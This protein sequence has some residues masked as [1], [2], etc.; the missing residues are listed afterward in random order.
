MS[1][2][3][4]RRK[5][6]TGETAIRVLCFLLGVLLTIS[7]VLIK[8]R[9]LPGI[10][11]KD[12]EKVIESE[13]AEDT[14][15]PE[16]TAASEEVESEEVEVDLHE[17]AAETMYEEFV[18]ATQVSVTESVEPDDNGVYIID[19]KESKLNWNTEYPAL[20]EEMTLEEHAARETSYDT[21]LTA[22]A[23]DK[24]V[25]ESST[26]DFS[27]VKISIMGDSITAAT[28]LSDEEQAQYS[29]PKLLSYILG[30]E[31]VNLGIGGSVVS[32]NA[33][34][35]P[36]VERWSDIPEDSDVIIIFGG[37]NDCLYMNKWDFG[38][39][40][41]DLRMNSGT[42]CG[43]LDEMCSAID[44]KFKD[45]TDKYVKLIYV[46]PMST[47]LNDGVYATD[48]GNMVEQR[49]FA[50]AINEIVPPYGFDIIDLY[51]SNYMNS[52]D[53]DVNHEFVTDG[54]HPNPVGYQMLAEHLASQII[55]RIN[56]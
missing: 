50:Q 56:Q 14:D 16:P 40:E 18:E 31:V 6:N 43:D 46:N 15:A 28:N 55:Q 1:E 27:G 23:F 9:F 21:T 26:V 32:R 8:E 11:D 39:I 13:T 52:H 4:K 38:H 24:K 41:Y 49:S 20:A 47:I 7:G 42:F 12:S 25:I 33:S 5:G 48:P 54:V 29:Y 17:A 53:W 34:N 3:N 44:W 37:T 2:E 45:N 30:C 10:L 35:S 36:M 19:G 51:N 22:N